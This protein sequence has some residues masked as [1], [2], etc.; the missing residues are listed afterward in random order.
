MACCLFVILIT[1]FFTPKLSGSDRHSRYELLVALNPEC[2]SLLLPQ[3]LFVWVL[4]ASRWQE[5]T[6]FES[7]LQIS[8]K[9][10]PS[11]PSVAAEMVLM[12]LLF[13]ISSCV[14][15]TYSFIPPSCCMDY[16]FNGYVCDQSSTRELL[17]LDLTLPDSF[18]GILPSAVS[19]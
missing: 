13:R 3:N 7:G 18:I 10:F 8:L 16:S 17:F 15:C 4:F 6:T 11:F 19:I 2:E 1:S 5:V 14:H 9:V 12:V